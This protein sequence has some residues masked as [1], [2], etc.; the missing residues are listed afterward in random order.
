M[1]KIYSSNTLKSNNDDDKYIKLT[2]LNFLVI[3]WYVVRYWKVFKVFMKNFS[4]FHSWFSWIEKCIFQT[5][6]EFTYTYKNYIGLKLELIN[7]KALKVT[8]DEY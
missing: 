4:C 5:L 7:Q 2:V 6:K 3:K 1:V 8:D